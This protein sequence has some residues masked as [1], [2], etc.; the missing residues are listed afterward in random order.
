MPFI[1]LAGLLLTACG[2]DTED[3]NHIDKQNRNVQWCYSPAENTDR[4]YEEGA[5]GCPCAAG[6]EPVCAS[7]S[8]RKVALVCEGEKWM[9][10]EDGP[11]A[12]EPP[13]L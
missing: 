8:T 1:L 11:C 9:A 13:S 4:A 7:T 6:S 5:M 3:K 2:R 10:V 12:P